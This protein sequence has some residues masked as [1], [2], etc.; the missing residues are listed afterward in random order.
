M[1]VSHTPDCMLSL[2]VSIASKLLLF[3]PQEDFPQSETSSETSSQ[4]GALPT[5]ESL[6][7]YSTEE[8]SQ[9]QAAHSDESDEDI[10]FDARERNPWSPKK[11]RCVCPVL[12]FHLC[13]YFYPLSELSRPMGM[14]NLG[15]R[16]PQK[17]V[18]NKNLWYF[19]N[20]I[21]PST[22]NLT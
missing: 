14:R 7:G 19:P 18:E 3:I 1:A 13:L 12:S 15:Y 10:F 21:Y 9:N 8:S 11:C 6:E 22:P 4:L 16:S 2:M 20:L 17:R 5:E